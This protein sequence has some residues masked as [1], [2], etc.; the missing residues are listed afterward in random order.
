M[1]A[2]LVPDPRDEARVALSGGGPTLTAEVHLGQSLSAYCTLEQLRQIVASGA[3]ALAQAERAEA[4]RAMQ[5]LP[6]E[7]VA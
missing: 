3:A 4:Q 7:A 5:L 2:V 1:R 6:L